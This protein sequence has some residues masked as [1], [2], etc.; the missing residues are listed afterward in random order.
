MIEFTKAVASGNDF[1]IVD[2]RKGGLSLDWPS[3]AKKVCERKTGIGADGL[4]LLEGSKKADVLMR[5]S[6]PDGSEVDMC[7]NGARCVVLY[8]NKRRIKVETKAGILEAELSSKGRV[9]VKMTDPKDLRT[10]FNI[11]L[12]GREHQVH[13][14]NTGVPH[15]VHFTEELDDFNV[16]E[17]GSLIR[18]H[19]I[20]QP[21]G[22]NAD[23]V[24]ALDKK[25][26]A[27]RTYER[28][29]EDETLA[30]G[31]GVC[32]SVIIASSVKGVSSPIDVRTKSGEVLKV[33]F[34]KDKDSYKD[35]YLEGEAELVFKG[36]IDV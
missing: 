27:V 4:L 5:V 34:S 11:N 1:V 18:Y 2:N 35:V 19:S 28:G 14:V 8:C 30:C 17:I 15:I 22:T 7:G 10:N 26:L 29:V 13:Y 23:F 33:Y 9:K 36:G 32:A 3:F 16:K 20:F 12:N 25:S 31:T 21:A 24:K 6:N